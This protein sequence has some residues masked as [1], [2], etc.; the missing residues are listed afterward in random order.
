LLLASAG[1]KR[2]AAA[3]DEA[4][5]AGVIVSRVNRGLLGY[6]DAIL[7]GRRGERELAT[8]TARAADADLAHYCVW[9]DLA[10]LQAAAP[11]LA[12]GWGQPQTWLE[13]GQV[14]FAAYGIDAL[15]A[16]CAELLGGRPPSR[17]TGLGITAREADV[18]LL[19]AEGL[20]NKEIA[21]RLYLSPRT[22]EKHVE[23][24]MRKAGARSR[25]QLVAIAGPQHGGGR[26]PAS[27]AG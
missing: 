20:A 9:G 21:A 4:V 17:W 19:V 8:E 16:R 7:A 24:L 6:A 26:G 15:A 23:S 12:D 10:R 25:T 27:A 13:A 22:I 5:R 18:L 14:S 3:I 1:D 11:A 2:A